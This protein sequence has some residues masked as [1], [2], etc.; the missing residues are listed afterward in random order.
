MSTHV[1]VERSP[2]GNAAAEVPHDANDD[3]ARLQACRSS[4]HTDARSDAGRWPRAPQGRSARGAQFIA[5]LLARNYVT[6]KWA[7]Y[8]RNKSNKCG[9]IHVSLFIKLRF[10]IPPIGYRSASGNAAFYHR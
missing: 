4:L 7:R 2:V 9:V 5:P 10:L 1:R 3:N 8:Q 6:G